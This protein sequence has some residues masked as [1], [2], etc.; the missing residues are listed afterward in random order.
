MKPHRAHGHSDEWNGC[1]SHVFVSLSSCAAAHAEALCISP[2][3]EAAVGAEF[4]FE[5][6]EW[7]GTEQSC[8]RLPAQGWQ[9][10]VWVPEK[11]GTVSWQQLS[12]PCLPNST[13]TVC[14]SCWD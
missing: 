3:P 4:G 11:A 6:K 1:G 7:V 13:G 14:S 10:E 8:A 9:G 5:S 12:A 2:Q